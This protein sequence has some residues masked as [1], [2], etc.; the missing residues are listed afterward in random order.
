MSLPT[1]LNFSGSQSRG[2]V[3]LFNSLGIRRRVS[4]VSQKTPSAGGGP[5]QS[6][7]CLRAARSAVMAACCLS[8]RLDVGSPVVL[9][10]C[11]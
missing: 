5:K 8:L 9:A 2:A 7:D 4:P 10:D 3:G 1:V 11:T 6:L